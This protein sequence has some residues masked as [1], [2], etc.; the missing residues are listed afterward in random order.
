MKIIAFYGAPGSG[1]SSLA[2]ACYS[3]MGYLGKNVGYCWEFIK[4]HAQR[5]E[6]RPTPI[7]QL[8]IAGNQ[9]QLLVNTVKANYDAVFCDSTP[10]LCAWFAEYYGKGMF[11]NLEP[12]VLEWEEQLQSQ[13]NCEIVDV[14]LDITPE[15]YAERY[16]GSGRWENFEEVLKMHNEMKEWLKARSKNFVTIVETTPNYVLRK[17]GLI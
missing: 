12:C 16:K 2:T 15:V 6:Y 11:K 9:S 8:W 13:Y 10:K 7:D 14:F 5:A 17:V 3:S 1:K 4:D